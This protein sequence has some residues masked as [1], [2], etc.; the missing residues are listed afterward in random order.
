VDAGKYATNYLLRAEVDRLGVGALSPNVS[1]YPVALSDDTGAKLNAT[2]KRYLVHFPA[3]DFPFPVKAFWSLSMYEASGF[4][5]PNPLER[6]ALG[7]RSE[8][9]FNEDGSL[10]VYL[11]TGEPSSAQQKENWLPAPAGEFHV[12][13]RLYATDPE[14][15]EPI[16]EGTAS[17]Q[18]PKIE[19]CLASGFTAGGQECAS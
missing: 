17:W 14:D 11:Q 1:I 4:F 2:S 8:L 6:Y 18:T 3:G 19:P 5:V 13:M 15:I 7:N 12:I 9:H 10:D 16:L